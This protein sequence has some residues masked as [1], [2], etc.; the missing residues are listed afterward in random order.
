MTAKEYLSQVAKLDRLINARIRDL[1]RIKELA[2]SLSAAPLQERVRSSSAGEASYT[3]G[4]MKIIAQ[5]EKINRDIDLLIDRKN[6][7]EALIGQLADIDEQCILRYR[8]IQMMSWDDIADEMRV[9]LRTIYRLH[10]RALK[11]FSEILENSQ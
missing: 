8:Y 1:K 5:E 9:S 7:A 2:Y 6:E 10:S 4:V 3:G 11:N